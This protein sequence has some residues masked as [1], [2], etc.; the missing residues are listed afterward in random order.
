[1]LKIRQIVG[2]NIRTLRL[3]SNITQVELAKLVGVSGS[4]IGYLERGKK[5]PSLDLLTKIAEGLNVSPDMLLISPD[6]K[7]NL[8]INKLK[9]ILSDKGSA[10]IQFIN[11]VVLAYFKSLDRK[12][13][14]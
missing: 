1:M 13:S 2:Q 3:K 10:A 6:D 7:K 4:Y 8:E 5:N 14:K 12:D 11:E 9:T